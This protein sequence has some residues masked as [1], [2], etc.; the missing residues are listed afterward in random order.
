VHVLDGKNNS[1][2]LGWQVIAAARERE[3]RRTDESIIAT[4]ER[5]R[6]SIVYFITLDTMEYLAKG[7]R[8]GGATKFL[9]TICA[10]K[11]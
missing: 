7:G 8:I 4:A 9:E 1:M 2:G 3:V 5:V 11:R 10:S 6:D